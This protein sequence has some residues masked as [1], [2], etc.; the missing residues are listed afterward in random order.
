MGRTSPVV[1]ADSPGGSVRGLP[2]QPLSGLRGDLPGGGDQVLGG[3]RWRGPGVRSDVRRLRRARP[4]SSGL[5]LWRVPGGARWS[6]AVRHRW[7]RSRPGRPAPKVVRRT[8]ARALSRPAAL[9]E[10][11]LKPIACARLPAARD[12]SR[13]RLRVAPPAAKGPLSGGRDPSDCLGQQPGV[14]GVGHIAGHHGGVGPQLGGAQYLGLGG[15]GQ[16]CP[17]Q[18]VHRR[19]PQ[20]VV[21]FINVVGCGTDP[22]NGIRQNRRHV[23]ESL[24]S[25]HRVS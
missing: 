21:S 17:V 12:R 14:G 3:R 9:R 6:A 13:T 10:R 11:S 15:L 22:S 23:I 2:G 18:P 8:A 4:G 5:W 19:G 7:R 24:T 16:Q 20:R 1:Q 25:R